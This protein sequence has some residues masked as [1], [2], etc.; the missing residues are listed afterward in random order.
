M[1]VGKRH[2]QDV[3]SQKR[4]QKILIDFQN[5]DENLTYDILSWMLSPNITLYCHRSHQNVT[6]PLSKTVM[7]CS[8]QN[9]TYFTKSMCLSTWRHVVCN[10]KHHPIPMSLTYLGM[11]GGGGVGGGNFVS[12]VILYHIVR[13]AFDAWGFK[14]IHTPIW[15]T[16]IITWF[17]VSIVS[18]NILGNWRGQEIHKDSWENQYYCKPI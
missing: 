7:N 5:R 14:S 1:L 18:M 11:G 16:Q 8:S 15:H 6:C 9:A 10:I 13:A 17:S 4:F 3:S 2:R 12:Q